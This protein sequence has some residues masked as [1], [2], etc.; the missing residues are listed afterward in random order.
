MGAVMAL[1]LNSGLTMAVCSHAHVEV[2]DHRHPERLST[3]A[4]CNAAQ[5]LSLASKAPDDLK[6]NL[7]EP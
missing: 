3:G 5:I 4:V 2:A 1:T 6:T 7:V